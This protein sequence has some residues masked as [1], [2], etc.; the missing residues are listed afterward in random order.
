MMGSRLLQK[1]KEKKEKKKEVDKNKESW[2]KR[3]KKKK[4]HLHVHDRC[5]N[6]ISKLSIYPK[7]QKRILKIKVKN[8]FAHMPRNETKVI[9]QLICL[10]HTHIYLYIYFW[11]ENKSRDFF[12][13]SF[14]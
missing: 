7:N 5:S 1:K 3:E 10:S 6:E 12:R 4:I 14:N 11:R 2:I 8:S 13:N 9:I